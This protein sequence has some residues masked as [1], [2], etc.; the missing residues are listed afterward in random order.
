V[1][2]FV[3]FLLVLVGSYAYAQ[4]SR[5]SITGQVT[6]PTGAT[7]S[8]AAVTVTSTDTGAI[9]RVN[10]TQEGFYTVPGLLPG[11]YTVRVTD[12]GFK[13]FERAGITLQTQQNL[14]INVKLEIGAA[15]E[16]ITVTSAPPLIDTADASVGQV[17][18]TEQV[19]DLPSNGGTPLGF[20]RI[21]YGAVVKA[22]HALG[23]ATPISN[24]TVDDFSL[25]GGNSASNELLLNGVPNMEDSGRTAGYSPQ[26]DSVN[27]I[28]VDVFGANV[29]YGDTSGGT[30]NI[31]TKSGTN[32]FHGSASWKY[33]AVGCSNLDGKYVSRAANDCTWMTALPY[34]Q[35]VGGT[36]TPGS[37]TNQFGG[38]IGGPIWIPKVFNGHNKLFFFYA[39]ETY[40]GQPPASTTT[41]SVPTAAERAG[42]FAPL[43]ALNTSTKGYAL[44]NPYTATGTSTNFSRTAISNNCLGPAATAYSSSDCPTNAGL[45][46][47]PIALAYLK[48]VPLPNYNGATTT[49]DGENNYSTFTPT[50]QDYRSHM[51]RIDWN[52]SSRDK[53]FGTAQRSRYLNQASNY[54]HDALSGT[55][56]DQIMFG[57][58]IDEIHT[59]SP[60]LFSDVRGSITRY[61]N[62]SLLSSSGISPTSLGFPAYLAQNATELAI[63]RVTFTDQTSPQS[64]SAEPGAV[65]NFDTLEL[66]AVVT[67]I[68]KAHTFVGGTDLRAYKYS[69]LATS[70]AD[71]YFSFSNTK[72]GPVAINNST[73]PA[74]FGS[75]WAE[76]MLGIPQGGSEDIFVPFQYNSFL[77]AFFVQDDWKVKRNMTVSIGIRAEH[78]LPVN[79]SQNRMTTAFNTSAT[80]ETTTAAETEY[81][82]HPSTLLAASSFLPV[83]GT[84]YASSSNRYAYLL[85]PVYWSPRLGITWS[86]DFTRGKGVVRLGFGIY[87]NPF[88]DYDTSQTYGYS[89]TSAYVASIN[90]YMTNNNWSDP[91][92][93][94]SSAPAVNPIQQPTGNSLGVNTNL[95][96][97]MVYY[98]PTIKVPYSERTSLDVQYQIGN[99]ILI[100]VGYI[101]NHQVHLSYSN[102]VDAVPLLPYL[103][104]S[105]YFDIPSNN[106]LTGTTFKN[107]GPATT[108][109][110]NPFKGLAGMTGTYATTGTLHAYQYL[111]AFPQFNSSSV[112][113]QLIPGSESTYNAFNARVAKLMGHGLTLNGVFEWSRLLGTFNQLNS[114]G[115]LNYG[116]T[117][118]DY[119]FHFAGY[120]TY[121]FPI[122]RG[123]QFFSND[124]R[125]VDG[126][127]GGWQISGIYQFLSGT[128]MSWGNAIYAG[129]GWKDFANHQH[130][131]TDVIGGKPVF[132]TSAFDTRTCTYPFV[133]GQTACNNDPT[134]VSATNPYNPS[135]QPGT[136]NFR[137]FPQYL[138]RQD[139]TSNWDANVQK[140]IKGRENTDLQLRLDCFNLLNRP[141]YNT[142]NVS[143]TSS[144]FGTVTGVYSGTT[145]RQFQV[146]AHFSF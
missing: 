55:N 141:Q 42:D 83:G 109:V 5:G 23:G 33:E 25:G 146:G 123:R 35:G 12:Q 142:P 143:P 81:A 57:A 16:Q 111:Q 112:T 59:F 34:A 19:E 91:F 8:N 77:N 3:L 31:T 11:G 69:S 7:V 65:E 15:S 13:A 47:S 79:E 113:E 120:G 126:F 97:K 132:N 128:P 6:D 80:N 86:P 137:T 36:T 38:T 118:S 92:S 108:D 61:D 24:S 89:A 58:Q 124:N 131:K 21:E 130:N 43:L 30:V 144:L 99:T 29:Q 32:Q 107:G 106:L 50:I 70:N 37:H 62:S 63:P 49:A 53:I 78:E 84:T 4:E 75:A 56:A 94:S 76:L 9:S 54:F 121:L 73:G 119:P 20:A 134:N 95:G 90:S 26:L 117:T 66:L 68:Y 2:H 105:Q 51:G 44:Y 22:K 122:G 127:V 140:D 103:S 100:E 18:T 133:T 1:K 46:L 101:N 125:I 96:A 85:P 114:G 115:A 64:W 139:Y 136:Y 40:R 27:E 82:A 28:R 41:T 17:L 104:H 45:A 39:Y 87:D 129:S 10:S 138:L 14:T 93:T 52:I 145:S 88:N 60:T 72:G 74:Y 67:K 48:L 116:E 110:T 71:A 98:S 135:L 102:T